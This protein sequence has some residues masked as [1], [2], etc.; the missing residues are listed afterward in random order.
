MVNLGENGYA[1]PEAF[2]QVLPA[3]V[4]TVDQY[5]GSFIRL[6]CASASGQLFEVRVYLA[7]WSFFAKGVTPVNSAGS[8]ALNNGL[9]SA[10][11]GEQLLQVVVKGAYELW[12]MFTSEM[13]LQLM[14]NLDEYEA[15][16]ELL[17]VS[18]DVA[19]LKFSPNKGFVLAPPVRTSQ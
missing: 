18:L 19:L 17:V 5:F 14:A 12:L 13:S 11:K 16:D 7:D 10:L 3:A 6:D 1:L 8:A 4:A 2:Q 15:G 9:L